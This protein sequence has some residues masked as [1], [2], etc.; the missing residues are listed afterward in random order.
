MK[1]LLSF[2]ALT[3]L[4]LAS[5][6]QSESEHPQLNPN[7]YTDILLKEYNNSSSDLISMITNQTFDIQ[8]LKEELD[9]SNIE[10]ICDV[11]FESL[12]IS[13]KYTTLVKTACENNRLAQELILK[14][15]ELDLIT[16][17]ERIDLFSS[18]S[19]EVMLRTVGCFEY[20]YGIAMDVYAACNDFQAGNTIECL[21]DAAD[22]FQQN[23]CECDLGC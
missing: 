22:A 16:S 2:I 11:E 13:K 23:F 15:P 5:C 8:N 1:H 9:G 7:I 12:S 10:D 18:S 21:Q 4:V 17:E 14:Y 3:I 19:S 20:A 6:S